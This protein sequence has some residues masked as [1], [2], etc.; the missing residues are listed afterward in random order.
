[1]VVMVVMVV[2]RDQ[3]VRVVEI[4]TRWFEERAAMFSTTL[5]P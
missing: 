5:T 3:G 1:M 2:T 4:I